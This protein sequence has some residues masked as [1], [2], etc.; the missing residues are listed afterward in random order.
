[1]AEYLIFEGNIDR[2]EQKLKTIENKCTKYGCEFTYSRKGEEFK[3][4][5]DEDGEEHLTRFIVVEAEG[6]AI[7]NGWRFVATI[8]HT[9]NGNI[10]RQMDQTV[11][12]PTKYRSTDPV[13]E[14]CNTLRRRKDTYIVY[15]EAS[16]E[17]KQVGKSCLM[18]FTKGLD[19]DAAARYIS[20]F[21]TLIQGESIGSSVAITN[22][23]PI[24]EILEY[25]AECYK[26][27]GYQRAG[28]EY[29]TSTRTLYYYLYQHGSLFGSSEFFDDIRDQIKSVDFD[30]SSNAKYVIDML[31]WIR[32]V[33]DID[34]DYM[35]NLTTLCK[36]T[37]V[38]SRNFG[39]LVSLV[40]TYNR[41]LKQKDNEIKQAEVRAKEAAMSEHIGKVRDRLNIEVAEAELLTTVSNLYGI[42]YLYKFKDANGNV[43]TWFTSCMIEVERKFNIVGT[44]KEHTTYRGVKQTVLTRC[45]VMYK[46]AA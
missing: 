1:M 6:T 34:S 36:D 14:H 5:R 16:D 46:E 20:W 2:L 18:D 12:V 26:H 32:T 30:A 41:Y 21:D 3:V 15:N 40:P 38:S 45:K 27:F 4:I 9:S 7:V 43:F 23:Y 13:C 10:I 44:V 22:Y 28:S 11:S 39:L 35:H 17:W 8:E 24:G 37:C 31:Q 29:P 42:S 19:A 33:D 25:A